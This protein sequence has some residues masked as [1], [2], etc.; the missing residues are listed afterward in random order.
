[1]G[2]SSFH[3]TDIIMNTHLKPL[4]ECKA[5]DFQHFRVFVNGKWLGITQRPMELVNKLRSMK[6]SLDI[7]PETGIA[8]RHHERSIFVNTDAGRCLRPLLI[9]D[10]G[11][12]RLTRKRIDA[13]RGGPG[14]R[15]KDSFLALMSEGVVELLDVLEEDN[16]LIAMFPKDLLKKENYTHMEIHPCTIYGEI[17]GSIPF[18]SH[19]PGPRTTFQSGES[20]FFPLHHHF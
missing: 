10:N 16:C 11:N 4:D 15:Y 2:D 19:N 1:M 6:R 3:L 5:D 13:L 20:F 17:A 8:I 12:L 18:L 9:V 14:A 7:N